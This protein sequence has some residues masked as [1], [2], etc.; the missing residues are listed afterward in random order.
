MLNNHWAKEA[1]QEKEMENQKFVLNR[2]RNK[3]IIN[4]NAMEKELRLGQLNAEKDRDKQMLAKQI[5]RE[6]QLDQLEVD[7]KD[8]RR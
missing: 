4:H 2:E 1:A 3:E 8:E 7:A 6:G 5:H